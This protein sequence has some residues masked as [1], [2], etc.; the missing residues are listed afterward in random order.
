[1]DAKAK[2]SFLRTNMT[3]A[4]QHLW[5]YLRRRQIEGYK[6]R[7]QFLIG[8]YI[9]DFICLERRLIIEIDGGQHSEQLDYDLK[10]TSY[11]SSNGFKVIRFW[12]SDVFQETNAVL[13]SIKSRLCDSPPP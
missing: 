4:E 11:L 12:N 9:V 10:R 6:F 13:E 3:D 7:R 2:A 1:M 8:K 5:K